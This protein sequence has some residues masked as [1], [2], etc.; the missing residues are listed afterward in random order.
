MSVTFAD[1]GEVVSRQFLRAKR[2]HFTPPSPS[3]PRQTLFPWPYAESLRFTTRW[4][5]HVTFVNAAEIVRRQCLA[6]TKLA[7]FFNILLEIHAQVDGADIPGGLI[8]SVHRAGDG[9]G[10]LIAGNSAGFI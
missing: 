9:H 8:G 6:R 4:I 7:D 5:K 3:L 1:A 10:I 2:I